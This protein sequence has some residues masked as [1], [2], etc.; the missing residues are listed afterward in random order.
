MAPVATTTTID[1]APTTVPVKPKVASV[2]DEVHHDKSTMSTRSR[3]AFPRPPKFTD[4]L[5]ER[6]Y[7]KF[8]LAQAFRIFGKLGYDEGVA[9][10][11]TVR[12]PIKTDCFWVNPFGLHF[13]LIQ[14]DDLLLVSHTGEILDESGPS[15]LLNTAAFAIH[16]AIHTARSDVLC[17]AHSH[18]VYGRSF[19]TLGKELD[20]ITQD[21]CAFYKDHTVYK[22]FNGVV[23]AEEE[24]K[25]IA[26]TLGNRKN[27]GLLVATS[28]IEATVHY[29]TALE[30][31]CQVQL[32]A[33][34]AGRT[35]KIGDEEAADT[36]KTV[37]TSY[38]G[39]FSGG[40][41]FQLLE[42]NEG[43]RFQYRK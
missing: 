7:L 16:S 35:V 28:S 36:Y 17:A 43:V 27:H 34:A 22:Q 8:R 25:N 5:E 15:R 39:W 6:A 10:H 3:T 26:E 1:V 40:P 29:F 32:L 24:G 20:M 21:S 12:D 18:S 37:G 11:I 33:D 31:S 42:A 41:A 23:L 9:G 30:K 13:S 19:S 2:E 38:G 4:K 14:P